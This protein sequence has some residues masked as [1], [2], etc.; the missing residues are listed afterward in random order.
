MPLT[1]FVIDSSIIYNWAHSF[2][3]YIENPKTV[4]FLLVYDDCKK[5]KVVTNVSK[6]DKLNIPSFGSWFFKMCTAASFV[7][8]GSVN[9]ETV[10]KNYK[11]KIILCKLR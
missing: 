1:V 10:H 3:L 2:V 9:F 5:I 4:L 11:I 7:K 8:K 6:K